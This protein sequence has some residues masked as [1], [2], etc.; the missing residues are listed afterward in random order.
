MVEATASWDVKVV[1]QAARKAA[2]RL[3]HP[4]AA[5]R[6]SLRRHRVAE[7]APRRRRLS[8]PLR[9]PAPALALTA[10]RHPPLAAAAAAAAA[11][12]AYH[13]TMQ[14]QHQRRQRPQASRRHF[15]HHPR[16]HSSP[17][18][19]MAARETL[20]PRGCVSTRTELLLP[21]LRVRCCGKWIHRTLPRARAGTLATAATRSHTTQTS[22]AASSAVVAATAAPASAAAPA[23]ATAPAGCMAQPGAKAAGA[24]AQTGTVATAGQSTWTARWRK[25]TWSTKTARTMTTVAAALLRRL[26]AL[27]MS[28]AVTPA[29]KLSN[30][31]TPRPAQPCHHPAG[32]PLRGLDRGLH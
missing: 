3:C 21:L 2:S 15:H 7:Q 30:P 19:C 20:A 17:Q 18:H 16:R 13:S 14:R 9:P 8:L 25:W 4:T 29:Q 5:E 6:P 32:A 1:A 24:A 23:T 22:S 26:P 27:P 12:T 31:D 10:S 11:A 28:T